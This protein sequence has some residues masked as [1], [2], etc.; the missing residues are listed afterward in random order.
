MYE[1]RPD[2]KVKKEWK[3]EMGKR[4]EGNK[5]AA[6]HIPWNKNVPCSEIQKKEISITLKNKY[7]SG[8]IIHPRGTLNM[9]LDGNWKKNISNSLK[10]KPSY[11]RTDEHR[12]KM[13]I[14]CK[15]KNISIK[16]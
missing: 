5:H 2:R 15:N 3:K 4:M 13:S 1:R 9:K 10:G 7:A 14:S 11:V 12:L 16:Y 8:E 6:G